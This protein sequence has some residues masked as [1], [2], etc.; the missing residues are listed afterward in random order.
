MKLARKPKAEK[1]SRTAKPRFRR[2]ALSEKR[3]DFQN[4][5][6]SFPF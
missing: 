4:E 1:E 5:K 3:L 2:P 6:F